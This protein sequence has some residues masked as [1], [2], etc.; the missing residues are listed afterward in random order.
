MTNRILKKIN[1]YSKEDP[2][3]GLDFLATGRSAE[4]EA[5]RSNP[6]RAVSDKVLFLDGDIEEAE[7]SLSVLFL[8]GGDG[9][10]VLTGGGLAKGLGDLEPWRGDMLG[11]DLTRP[12]LVL[13]TSS[14]ALL[15]EPILFLGETM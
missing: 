13:I 11:R 1:Q 10:G 14:R 9:E 4:P 12:L 3:G 5:S 8:A 6:S 2:S 15:G 7:L